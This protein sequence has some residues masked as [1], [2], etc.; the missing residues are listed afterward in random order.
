MKEKRV[1]YKRW[2]ESTEQGDSLRVSGDKEGG[3]EESREPL[4]PY[5]LK[6]SQNYRWQWKGVGK[7]VPR[8]KWHVNR[9]TREPMYVHGLQTDSMARVKVAGMHGCPRHAEPL[10]FKIFDCYFLEGK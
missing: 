6:D 8:K 1:L 3:I 10:A 5:P 4:E 9:E 2:E 7:T